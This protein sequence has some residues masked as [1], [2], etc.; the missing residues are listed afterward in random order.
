[1]SPKGTWVDQVWF[2]RHDF[3]CE[4]PRP[5][6]PA[7]VV[8]TTKATAAEAIST[9]SPATEPPAT[10]APTT[11]AAVT[12]APS[13]A[14]KEK[15]YTSTCD[16]G[17]HAYDNSCYLVGGRKVNRPGAKS[18]CNRLGAQLVGI[19]DKAENEACLLYTSP[20]PRDRQKSRMPS[21]A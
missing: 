16:K 9:E 14:T 20:S 8:P 5:K 13:E 19:K 7:T 2:K 12:K 1:M 21:S 4:K 11:T 6:A 17:W 3:V 18:F 10:K 15:N